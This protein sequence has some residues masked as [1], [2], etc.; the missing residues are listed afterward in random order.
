MKLFAYIYLV[1]LID[2]VYCK[3]EIEKK[4]LYCSI[5]RENKFLYHLIIKRKIKGY[6][7]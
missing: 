4:F 3:A 6:F 5:I 2:I 1:I 7:I